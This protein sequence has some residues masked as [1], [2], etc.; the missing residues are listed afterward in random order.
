MLFGCK[1]YALA[2]PEKVKAVKRYS[3]HLKPPSKVEQCHAF[4]AL[5][6]IST[7]M[8]ILE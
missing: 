7:E 2:K 1:L 4:L 8:A 3:S 6:V 5:F